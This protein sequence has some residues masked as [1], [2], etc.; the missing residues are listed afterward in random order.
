[1]FLTIE[2]FGITLTYAEATELYRSLITAIKYTI[3]TH[4]RQHKECFP[5]D[6]STRLSMCE[7]LSLVTGH[8]HEWEVKQLTELLNNQEPLCP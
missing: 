1:M 6:E 8:N 2:K 3:V 7:Q 4:W 5:A